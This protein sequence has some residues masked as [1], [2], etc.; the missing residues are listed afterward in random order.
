M[1]VRYLNPDTIHSTTGY[2]H[3]VETSGGRTVYISGQIAFDRDGKLVGEG[4]MRAQAEQV[5]ANLKAALEAA[6]GGFQHLVKVVSYV[7]DWSQIAAFR[8]V[9]TKYM[10]GPN[11]PASTLLC[12][13]A[14]ALPSFL[15]EVDA[16]AVIPD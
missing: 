2:T 4:D 12:V 7:A 11:P 9:R 6:G 3:V 13:A 10:S 1:A 16:I 14:L 15:V 8:E 5:F